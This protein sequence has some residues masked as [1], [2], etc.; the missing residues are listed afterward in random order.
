MKSSTYQYGLLIPKLNSKVYFVWVVASKWNPENR[1]WELF[2]IL[3]SYC[4]MNVNPFKSVYSMFW[5]FLFF[6]CFLLP[7]QTIS[8]IYPI[9]FILKQGR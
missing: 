6:F 5:N 2:K 8:N 3:K 4:L 1:I 7:L 9:S